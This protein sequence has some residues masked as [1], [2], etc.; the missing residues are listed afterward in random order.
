M[1]NN[2]AAGNLSQ[3]NKEAFLGDVAS[4]VFFIYFY[5]GVQ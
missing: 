3:V 2:E 5:S 4:H 1:I